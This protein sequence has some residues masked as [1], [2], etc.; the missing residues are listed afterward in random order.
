MLPAK[1]KSKREKILQMLSQGY[2]VDYIASKLNTTKQNVYKERSKKKSLEYGKE[3]FRSQHATQNRRRSKRI[4]DSELAQLGKTQDSILDEDPQYGSF[5]TL[6]R[7]TKKE[8][9]TLFSE[10]LAGKKPE[11]II[12]EHGIDP[13]I[14]EKEYQRF[15]KLRG[16]DRL[17]LQ[18]SI[19]KLSRTYSDDLRPLINKLESGTMLSNEEVIMLVNSGCNNHV[20]KLISDVKATLPG[21]IIRASCSRCE[22]YIPGILLDITNPDGSRIFQEEKENYLCSD[23]IQ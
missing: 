8:Y 21:L 3:N 19:L 10:F 5:K 9:S 4:M 22:R 11:E 23:C 1:K 14:V 18:R 12:A 20:L 13:E 2:S 16:M 17:E 7:P 15:L 6:R